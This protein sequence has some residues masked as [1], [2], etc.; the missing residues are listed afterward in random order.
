M[1]FLVNAVARGLQQ[2]LIAQLYREEHFDQLVREREDVAAKR[3]QCTAA[4]AALKEALSALERL[5]SHLTARVRL[6]DPG[7]PSACAWQLHRLCSL[8]TCLQ[9]GITTGKGTIDH[10]VRQFQS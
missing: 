10:P 7:C 6:Q 3:Q 5:P 9:P 4:L 1:H 8:L 2:H